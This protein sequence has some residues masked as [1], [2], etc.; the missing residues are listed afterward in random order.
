MGNKDFFLG[1]KQHFFVSI[2]TYVYITIIE[3]RK[4]SLRSVTVY[5]LSTKEHSQDSFIRVIQ[6]KLK[7]ILKYT[8]ENRDFKKEN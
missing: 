5:C 2:Y 8:K 7:N 4:C 1:T 3:M 6:K